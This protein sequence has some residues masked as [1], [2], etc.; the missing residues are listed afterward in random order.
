[1]LLD[2]EHIGKPRKRRVVRYNTREA[3]LLFRFEDAKVK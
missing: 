2:D 1:M 3:D